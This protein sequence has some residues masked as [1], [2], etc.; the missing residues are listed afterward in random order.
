MK[1]LTTMLKDFGTFHY[2]QDLRDRFRNARLYEEWSVQYP[3]LFDEIVI[4]HARGQA[5]DGYHFHEWLAAILIHKSTGYSSLFSYFEPKSQR[6]QAI[7]KQVLP[8]PVLTIVLDRSHH[9]QPPDI[10]FYAP[11]RS[12]WF[13]CEVKGPGD[14]L[15]KVQHDYYEKISAVTARPIYLLT[16]KPM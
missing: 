2:K 16:L 1:G 14:R 6:E 7:L 4:S 10:F 13:F 8:E 12:D 11:D 15:R 9:C 3:H 5:K